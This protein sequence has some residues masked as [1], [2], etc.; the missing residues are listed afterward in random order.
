VVKEDLLVRS[1]GYLQNVM[2]YSSFGIS[3]LGILGLPLL[4]ILGMC[5]F[6]VVPMGKLKNTPIR[7]HGMV[8]SMKSMVVSFYIIASIIT[9]WF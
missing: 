2:A 7:Y 6:D 3:T 4:K 5:H 9:F 1:C 8:K